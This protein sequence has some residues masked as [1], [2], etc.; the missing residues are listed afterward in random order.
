MQMG[1]QALPLLGKQAS[2]ITSDQGEMMSWNKLLEEAKPLIA[3]LYQDDFYERAYFGESIN[4]LITTDECVAIQ[5]AIDDSFEKFSDW[6]TVTDSPAVFPNSFEW[7]RWIDHNLSKCSYFDLETKNFHGADLK[8]TNGSSCL[9]IELMHRD[10]RVLLNC[11]ANN[12]F[13]EIWLQIL[14]VYLSSGFPCGWSGVQPEG[15]LVV[16]SN[17]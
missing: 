2:K 8:L 4:R 14:S 5:Y 7:K 17:F 1:F 9:L 13:P 10:I 15:K 3:L 16:F 6:Q 12:F 11:Y